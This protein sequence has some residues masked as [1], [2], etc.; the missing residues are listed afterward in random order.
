LL[1]TKIQK[2]KTLIKKE[3]HPKCSNVEYSMPSTQ[4]K[5][6]DYWVESDTNRYELCVCWWWASYWM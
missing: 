3:L 1:G 2:A 5:N 6:P 4:W